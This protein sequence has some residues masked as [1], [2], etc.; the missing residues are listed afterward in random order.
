[1]YSFTSNLCVLQQTFCTFKV[2]VKSTPALDMQFSFKY[3]FLHSS[4]QKTK[5]FSVVLNCG[6][7]TKMKMALILIHLLVV[8]YDY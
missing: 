8:T 2:G 3:F 7:D 1:M 4:L 6:N 5:S